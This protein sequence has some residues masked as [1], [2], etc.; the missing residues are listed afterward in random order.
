LPDWEYH[1]PAM[2]ERFGKTQKPLFVI[3]GKP[4]IKAYRSKFTPFALVQYVDWKKLGRAKK[5][6]L[7][8][9]TLEA[10]GRSATLVAEI[11][12]GAITRLRLA[13][14]PDCEQKRKPRKVNEKVFYAVRDKLMAMRGTKVTPPRVLGREVSDKDITIPIW[15][16]PP[17]VIIVEP[18]SLCVAIMVGSG[19]VGSHTVFCYYCYGVGG[20]CLL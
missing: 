11:E 13:G 18:E 14:C 7:E 8:I 10:A 20:N 5:Q 9:G 6:L 3:G 12:R 16:W 1:F 15:P 17:I 2:A 4:K 19:Q